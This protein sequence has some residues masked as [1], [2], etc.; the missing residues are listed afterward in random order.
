MSKRE[1][2]GENSPESKR[3]REL[4]NAVEELLKGAD[5]T[6][7]TM[8]ADNV[9]HCLVIGANNRVNHSNT[10][11]IGD[12]IVTTEEFQVLVQNFDNVIEDWKNSGMVHEDT[13]ASLY[14]LRDYHNVAKN[15]A[16]VEIIDNILRTL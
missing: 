4:K 13:I 14:M 5:T 6:C 15:Q 9:H 10:I 8:S 16:G 2:D 11:I 3:L 1:Y 7:G 12:G